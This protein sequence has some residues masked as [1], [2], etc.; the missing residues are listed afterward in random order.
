MIEQQK[1]APR[2]SRARSGP[3][4]ATLQ[5]YTTDIM[6]QIIGDLCTI[7]TLGYSHGLLSIGMMIIFL[8]LSTVLN[9][10]VSVERI[11]A[12]LYIVQLLAGTP[13]RRCCGRHRF[14]DDEMSEERIKL[15]RQL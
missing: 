1:K 8:T 2:S 13:L 10:S 12:L 9:F 15:N 11:F 3:W 14:S 4:S 6:A 5:E 7:Y